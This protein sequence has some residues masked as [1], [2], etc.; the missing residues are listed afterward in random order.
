MSIRGNNI[1]FSSFSDVPDVV[2][3]R[4]HE[5]LRMIASEEQDSEK[6]ELYSAENENEQTL[7]L[8]DTQ[9]IEEL[10]NEDL[11]LMMLLWSIS[12]DNA[13]CSVDKMIWLLKK[14]KQD[15]AH[16]VK[17][18]LPR[19]IKKGY[20]KEVVIDRELFYT[21]LVQYQTYA[22]ARFS[23][24]LREAGYSSFLSYVA[25]YYNGKMIDDDTLEDLWCWIGAVR[26]YLSDV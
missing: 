21:V 11:F 19:L 10:I 23:Q 6:E 13:P 18:V 24:S 7:C 17:I 25:D 16:F 5:T 20:L 8:I 26:G 15:V 12:K 9:S 2:S 1:Y 3:K 4:M 14:E 22:K